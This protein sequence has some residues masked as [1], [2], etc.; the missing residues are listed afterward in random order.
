MKRAHPTV[1]AAMLFAALYAVPAVAKPNDEWLRI[2]TTNFTLVG[3]ASA[4]DI[5]RVAI[6]LEEF[7]EAFR[8]VFYRAELTSPVPTTVVVFKSNLAYRPFKPHRADG[9]I[10]DSITGY[11]MPLTILT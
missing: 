5:R 4:A 10:D 9:T 2:R 8:Q 11:F 1:L 6:R 3:N 7:R